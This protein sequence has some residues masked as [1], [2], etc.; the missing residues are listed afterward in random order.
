MFT[1][2]IRKILLVLPTACIVLVILFFMLRVIPGDPAIAALGNEATAES[3]EALRE[4]LGL[5]RPLYVQFFDYLQG[6]AKGDLG[7]SLITRTSIAGEIATALP[8]TMS[9]T[10]SSM[11]LAIVLGISLGVLTAVKRNTIIDYLGRI[12]SLA[13]LSFPVFFMGLLLMFL[14]AIKLN[15]LPAIGA[16]DFKR[17]ILPALSGGLIMTAYITRLTRSTML[18]VIRED[19]IA[20][21]RAKGLRES[22]VI[23]RHALKNA[24]ISIATIVGMYFG[25]HFA[26]SIMIEMIFARPGIG[27]LLVSAIK[28]NDYTMV[29]SIILVYCFI[30]I[31]VNLV[32][33]LIYG[34]IDPRIVYK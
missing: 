1:Y 28:Q 14:F 26:G 9:Y 27:K 31:I 18:D 32:T 34:L 4:E 30:I 10:V 23:F 11:F 5:N 6:L 21:A 17:L 33:D 12:F 2:A 29:Q 8:Y 19:Y 20:T 25:L 15:L 22:V 16:G 24:L 13:G 3:L 7:R